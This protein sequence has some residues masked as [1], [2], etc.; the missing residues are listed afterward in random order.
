MYRVIVGIN[1]PVNG[2][3]KRAE[4]GD[5]ISDL[6][7]KDAEWMLADGVIEEVEPRKA[8]PKKKV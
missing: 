7:P 1:Y 3:E 5:T 8:A 6:A 2:V 4:P